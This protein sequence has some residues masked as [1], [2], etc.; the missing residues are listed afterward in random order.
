MLQLT[1]RYVSFHV[2]FASDICFFVLI[3]LM[4][5]MDGCLDYRFFAFLFL[6]FSLSPPVA[7]DV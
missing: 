2:D 7:S 6:I 5:F 3:F 4:V 1:T